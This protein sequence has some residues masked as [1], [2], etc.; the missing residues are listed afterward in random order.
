VAGISRGCVRHQPVKECLFGL[1]RAQ[2]PFWSSESRVL[3]RYISGEPCLW[4]LACV[5][6]FPS[7]AKFPI[8]DRFHK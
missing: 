8:L 3:D 2:G 6:S 7:D 5:Q 1:L 4:R